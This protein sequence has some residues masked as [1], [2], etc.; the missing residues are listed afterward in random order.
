MDP[1][2]RSFSRLL[3]GH[4]NF[5]PFGAPSNFQQYAQYPP[6]YLGFQQ[7]PQF[8]HSGGIFGSPTG[9]SSHGSD[10]ATPQSHRREVEQ[11]KE[12]K[13]SNGSSPDKGRRGVIINY[14]EEE[15]LRLASAWLKHFVDPVNGNDKTGEYYWRSVAEEFNSTKPIGGRTRSKGQLKSHGAKFQQAGNII[16]RGQVF[17]VWATKPRSGRAPGVAWPLTG[18]ELE[19]RRCPPKPSRKIRLPRSGL[20]W[21]QTME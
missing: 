20:P 16:K 13:D 18:L 8:V 3:G 6:N 15:N 4:K 17:F 11:A 5:N 14:T 9:A 12:V 21:P 10:S 2:N 7:Q 19:H 1:P